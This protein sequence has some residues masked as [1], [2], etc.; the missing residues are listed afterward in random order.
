MAIMTA[1]GGLQGRGGGTVKVSAERLAPAVGS[2]G[3][4]DGE[5]ISRV[6]GSSLSKTDNWP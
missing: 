1:R 4:G 2:S 5:F 3:G 6:T